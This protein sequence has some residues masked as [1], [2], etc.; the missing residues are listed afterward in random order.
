MLVK[1]EFCI[2]LNWMIS[3]FLSLEGCFQVIAVKFVFSWPFNHSSF[4][5]AWENHPFD[6]TEDNFFVFHKFE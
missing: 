4:A 3:N 1:S 6:L 5:S 2:D